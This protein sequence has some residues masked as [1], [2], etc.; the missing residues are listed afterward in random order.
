MRVLDDAQRLLLRIVL[1]R[2]IPPHDE[3]PG[4][5]DL[6]AGAGI[7]GTLGESPRLRRL[8]LDGLTDI[9]VSSS[10]QFIDLDATAQAAVLQRVEQSHPVFFAALVEQAYRAYYTLPKVQQAVGWNRPPQPMGHT[11]AQFDPN[12]LAQQ[13]SRAPFWRRAE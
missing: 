1:N 7:E 12:L 5:G 3:L 8:F 11:L 9:Q 10:W 6:D 13:W 4:A 2:V